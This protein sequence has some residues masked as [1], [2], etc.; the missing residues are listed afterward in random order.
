MQVREFKMTI[1]DVADFC[2]FTGSRITL[3]SADAGFIRIAGT[4]VERRAN[5]DRYLAFNEMSA[6]PS[7]KVVLAEASV[8]KVHQGGEERTLDRRQFQTELET[9]QKKLGLS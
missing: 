1:D 4:G 5:F 2:Q 6:L 7:P 9:F 8:F 3:G